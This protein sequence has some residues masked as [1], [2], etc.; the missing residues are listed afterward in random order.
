MIKQKILNIILFIFI[1][2]AS[3][4]SYAYCY[5]NIPK[6]G[7]DTAGINVGVGT[8]N[9]TDNYIQPPGSIIA[10]SV[11]NYAPSF[12]YPSPDTVVYTCDLEDRDKIYEIFATNGDDLHGG[13]YTVGAEDGLS[14]FY[15]S[16]I[17][18]TGIKLTHLNT[19]ITF[20]KY[21]QQYPITSYLVDGNKIKI[22]AKDFSAVKVEIAK[23]SSQGYTSGA[24]SSFCG[25]DWHGVGPYSCTQPNGYVIF[26]GPGTGETPPIGSDS[27]YNYQGFNE[28][29]T[30]IGMVTPP[31]TNVTMNTT[32]VARNVTPVI[33]FPTMSISELNAG[34]TVQNNFTITVECS[35]TVK[36]GTAVGQTAIGIQTSLEAYQTAKSLGLVNS[37]GGVSFLLSDG[38]G[39]DTKIATGV[40]ITLISPDGK[41]LPFVGWQNCN[42]GGSTSLC[43]GGKEAGWFP[44]L[45]GAINGGNSPQAGYQYLTSQ[46]TAILQKIPNQTVTPGTIHAKG[47]VLVRVQ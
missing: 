24:A 6:A 5:R 40:G 7:D 23:V 19:G 29:W 45:T 47:Y 38:Y 15:Q 37:N 17:R 2:T 42:G 33:L 4:N 1:I 16:K 28:H 30:S 25:N 36:S 35:N 9:V 8:V 41:N 46:F 27:A 18:Y 43:P 32:C 26:K 20:T 22:R 3:I 14:G 11:I 39:T 44:I 34:K 31:R 21:W 12:S 13:F 10:S